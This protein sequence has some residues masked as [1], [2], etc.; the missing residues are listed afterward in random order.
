[1][2][3]P[4]EKEEISGSVAQKRPRGSPTFLTPHR[5][6]KRVPLRE[7]CAATNGTVQPRRLS[8]LCLQSNSEADH[9]PTKDENWNDAELKALIE[10]ILFHTTG[11]NWPTHKQMHFWSSASDFV[12]YRSG[13]TTRRS[14]MSFYIDFLTCMQLIVFTVAS[15]CRSVIHR[16]LRKQYKTPKDAEK[17]YI[18][19]L[20]HDATATEYQDSPGQHNTTSQ[21]TSSRSSDSTQSDVLEL[22][23][24][25]YLFSQLQGDAQL[26]ILSAL[27]STVIQQKMYISVPDDFLVLA[28]KAMERLRHSGR[29]NVLYKLAKGFGTMRKDESDSRFP[30]RKMPMGLVEYT[31]DFFAADNLQSV[32]MELTPVP[33][34][35]FVL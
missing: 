35:I 33:K 28:A 14:G 30:T 31:A 11:E 10:F 21:N 15:A 13:V 34:F 6:Q 2:S 18:G 7:I 1:M 25:Q 12:S 5:C 19:E 32:G 17:N 8:G 20:Q 16:R 29:S 24:F 27:F 22:A 3:E 23:A 9:Q 26:E 4:S